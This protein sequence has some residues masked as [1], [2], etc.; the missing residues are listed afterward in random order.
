MALVH[1]YSPDK[2]VVNVG[3]RDISGFA[4]E[5]F[6][7]VERNSE[8]FTL[9]VGSDGE[10]TRVKSLNRSGKITI[11]LQQSALSNDYLSSLATQDELTS[12]AVVP[13]L[14]KEVTGLTIAQA[15]KSW[16]V[17][18]A[19]IEYGTQSGNREWVL[20]THDLAIDVAGTATL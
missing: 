4:D 6:V 19:P 20:E 5:T 11:T 18:K 9:V 14:V 16:V 7:K 12:D 3:G 10:A 13:S 2:V 1:S 8:A 17:K 15:S